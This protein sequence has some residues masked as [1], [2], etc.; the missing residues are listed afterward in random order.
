[1]EL[2]I[3][4][5]DRPE[6]LHNSKR[7]YIVKSIMITISVSFLIATIAILGVDKNIY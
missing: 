6:H 4:N 1:M 7:F 3:E 5:R 2:F